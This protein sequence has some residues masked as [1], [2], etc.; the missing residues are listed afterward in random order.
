M[1]VCF[2]YSKMKQPIILWLPAAPCSKEAPN[3]YLAM[4][5]LLLHALVLPLPQATVLS[6]EDSFDSFEEDSIPESS[7]SRRDSLKLP[8]RA[9]SLNYPKSPRSPRIVTSPSPGD[10]PG[11]NNTTPCVPSCLC[12][13][14]ASNY[15][16]YCH[17]THFC[18]RETITIVYIHTKFNFTYTVS[19]KPDHTIPLYG[20]LVFALL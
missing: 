1:H 11:K 7:V 8:I 19:L 14:R 13:E 17:C 9:Q 4:I 3:L 6:P 16:E 20:T 18:L 10:M 15:R 12:G 2:L 5:Y